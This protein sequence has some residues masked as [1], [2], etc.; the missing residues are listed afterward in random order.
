MVQKKYTTCPCL[1]TQWQ[2]RAVKQVAFEPAEGS[3]SEMS[4]GRT[5]VRGGGEWSIIEAEAISEKKISSN[6]NPNFT[7]SLYF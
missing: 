6:K 5:G 2:S 7:S 4:G 1:H 3:V